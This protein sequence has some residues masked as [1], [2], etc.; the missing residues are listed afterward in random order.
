MKG[1][2][3]TNVEFVSDLTSHFHRWCSAAKVDYFAGL[4][5]L[6]ILEQFKTV[7]PQRVAAYF[8]EQKPS[9]A[10]TAAEL[11]DDLMREKYMYMCM[12]FEIEKS[13]RRWLQQYLT[14]L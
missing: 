6:I 2:K 1:D 13:C 8:N 5:E 14:L 10:L 9:T 11:A 3:Q 12:Y 7:I 4:T